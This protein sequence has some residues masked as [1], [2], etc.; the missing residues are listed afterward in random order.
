MDFIDIFW[1][2]HQQRR[3][4]ELE[5][6]VRR[7][8]REAG[9]GDAAVGPLDERLARLTL[10]CAAMWSLLKSH[11]HTDQELLDRMEEI[12]L[13]DGTLDGRLSAKPV[14]CPQCGR[15]SPPE[16]ARCLFCSAELPATGPFGGG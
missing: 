4:S 15:R 10:A 5:G 14:D 9:R 11:G 3:I 13:S 2:L 16:R 12:D 6:S 8:E 1:N 7:A